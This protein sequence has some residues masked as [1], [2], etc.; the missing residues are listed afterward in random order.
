MSNE[1]IKTMINDRIDIGAKKYGDHID[2]NDGRDWLQE[3]LEELLDGIVY[4]V[5]ELLKIKENRD[6]K[7]KSVIRQG[8][9]KGKKVEQ[10]ING[11][12]CEEI[13]QKSKQ[14]I[15]VK[16]GWFYTGEG[17]GEKHKFFVGET[18]ACGGDDG[19]E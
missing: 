10:E 12:E 13:S 15:R 7:L 1:K 18:M 17:T 8:K 6:V 19:E 14:R 11:A 16:D 3:T 2:V 9:E 5:C 4:A